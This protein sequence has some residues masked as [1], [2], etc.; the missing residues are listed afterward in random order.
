MKKIENQKKN[1][2]NEKGNLREISL[3]LRLWF[4]ATFPL[5]GITHATTLL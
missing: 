1:Q 2:K 5:T 4:P 3:S